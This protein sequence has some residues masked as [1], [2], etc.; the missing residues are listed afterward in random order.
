MLRKR[1]QPTLSWSWFRFRIFGFFFLFFSETHYEIKYGFGWK[2]F[3]NDAAQVRA[4]WLNCCH[5][6]VVQTQYNRAAFYYFRASRSYKQ[7]AHSYTQECKCKYRDI[8]TGWK[9]PQFQPTH[10]SAQL[11]KQAQAQEQQKCISK[12]KYEKSQMFKPYDLIL[13]CVYIW[14]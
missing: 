5:I 11:M 8:S 12:W 14:S 4:Y 1:A 6:F 2:V 9:P 3:Q 13:L 10:K 7:R